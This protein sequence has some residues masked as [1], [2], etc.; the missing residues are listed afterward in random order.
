MKKVLINLNS[1]NARQSIL[2]MKNQ[3]RLA[4]ELIASYNK[5][6]VVPPIETAGDCLEF[7]KNPVGF[8]NEAIIN[9]CG[10]TFGKA[11]PDPA[12]IA[13]MFRIP[14]SG[15]TVRA[16]GIHLSPT[17]L[18]MLGFDEGDKTVF[19]M[20]E[21]E[22]QIFENAK[23][24]L[25]NEAEIEE[26]N[27]LQEVCDSLNELF[28][29]FNISGSDINSAGHSLPFFKAVPGSKAGEGWKLSPDV[30]FVKKIAKT[31]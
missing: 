25:T 24:Y 17:Q 18:S 20:A 13:A 2:E 10:L 7:L 3:C 26:Y 15:I 29:R 31:L 1:D 4:T 21:A 8:M 6:P 28:T 22:E 16:Q 19:L 9:N 11:K 30:T 23:I 5:M 12:A 27:R 14:S